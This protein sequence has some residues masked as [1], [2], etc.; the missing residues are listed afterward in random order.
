MIGPGIILFMLIIAS[1]VTIYY[2]IRS[3]H[4]EN[5]AKIEYGIT[6][7]S[8]SP[9]LRPLLNLGIFLCSLGAGFLL[10]Y[11]V[12]QYSGVPNYIA[13]PTCLLCSGGAG[14]ILNYIINSNSA[15]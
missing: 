9:N 14:L 4:I 11:F 15:Q 5:M 13:M 3:K 10:A 6:E 8:N 1:T 7:D 2:I 12:S